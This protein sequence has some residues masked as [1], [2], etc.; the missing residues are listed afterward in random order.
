MVILEGSAAVGKTS[1][2]NSLKEYNLVDRDKYICKLFDFNIS[3][4]DRVSKL[5]EYLASSKDYVIFLI[6]NDCEELERRISLR[7]VI[8]EF[9]RYTYLY[10]LL[11]LEAYLYMEKNDMLNKRLFMVDCTDLGLDEVI[12][13]VKWI[14]DENIM[15]N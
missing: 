7:V 3:L 9:D 14:I 6:N 5:K 15:I 11:Y 1:V 8:D 2:I 12:N 4:L 13:K 10:N